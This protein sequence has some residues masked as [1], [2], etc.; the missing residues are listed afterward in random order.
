[1]P[2]YIELKD[3]VTKDE[4]VSFKIN[5][6]TNLPKAEEERE[7]EFR[8]ISNQFTARTKSVFADFSNGIITPRPLAS[9]EPARDKRI[10][11]CTYCNFASVCHYEEAAAAEHAG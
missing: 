1:M 8:K 10:T 11:A 7:D 4:A 3:M 9:A 2:Y 5:G 6:I